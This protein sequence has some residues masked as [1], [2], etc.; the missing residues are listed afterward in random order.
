MISG[1]LV[2]GEFIFEEIDVSV[3]DIG[4][5]SYLKVCEA[6]CSHGETFVAQ[7][8]YVRNIETGDFV[9]VARLRTWPKKEVTFL[10][11]V[12]EPKPPGAT[13]KR[14]RPAKVAS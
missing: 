2:D 10:K 5:E 12:P 3:E 9:P 8:A 4:L 1:I 11:E 14:G 6:T 13:K 7:I